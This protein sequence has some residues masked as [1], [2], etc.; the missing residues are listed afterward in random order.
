[1]NP[2]LPAPLRG[3]VVPA[4]TPLKDF[5]TLDEQGLDNLIEHLIAGGVNGI[6][7]LGTTGEGTSL[8]YTLRKEVIRKTCSKVNGRLPVLV[9]ITDTAFM[10]SVTVAKMA[11]DAGAQGVVVAHPPYFPAADPEILNYLEH[12]AKEVPLPIFL[13]NMPSHTKLT[14]APQTVRDAADID[15]IVGLKDSSANLL[16]LHK[17]QMLL[18]QKP[19]FTFL[20]GPEELLPETVMMGGHGGVNGGANICPELYVNLYKASAERDFDKIKQLHEKVMQISMTIY[21]VGA[22]SSYLR[23]LKC[24][25]SCVGICSDGMAEPFRPFDKEEKN[26]VARYVD[27]LGLKK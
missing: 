24:A 15:G 27:E 14:F 22:Y 9:G 7:I 23:G 13:Y 5:D 17:I 25:V 18:K 1:M 12:L 19:D 26:T 8:S 11:Q 3:I 21:S 10:E 20:V 4:I 16:Y 6:F 2:E